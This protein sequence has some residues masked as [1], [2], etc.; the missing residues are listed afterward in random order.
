MNMHAN[1]RPPLASRRIVG[2]VC[3]IAIA[4]FSCAPEIPAPEGEPGECVAQC[5]G[6]VCGSDGCGG[7]C[8][9]CGGQQVCNTFGI[10]VEC[11]D[12]SQ[13]DYANPCTPG[14]CMDG[15]CQ[16]EVL[17]D[18]EVCA[19]GMECKQGL[20]TSVTPP[21]QPD[22]AGKQCG[23]DGCG[24]ECAS[25]PEGLFCSNFV[26]SMECE[27]EC[28][29]GQKQC[30]GAGFQT[31][32]PHDEHTC[33]VWGPVTPCGIGEKCLEGKCQCDPDCTGKQCGPDGCGGI[34]G[35]CGPEQ[36]CGQDFHCADV[37]CNECDF[38]QQMQCEDSLE[39][40]LCEYNEEGCLLWSEDT[41]G[42]AEGKVCQN[43]ECKCDDQCQGKECGPDGCGGECGS[44]PDGQEC[45]AGGSCIPTCTETCVSS[46]C[47]CGVVCG[48]SCGSC[49]LGWTCK[50][51]CHCECQ[52]SCEGKQCGDDGCGESCGDCQP[53]EVCSV[54]DQCHCEDECADAGAKQCAWSGY[55]VC[56]FFGSDDCLTW[57]DEIPCPLG[58]ECVQGSCFEP[59]GCTVE[60]CG[61]SQV[62]P[63]GEECYC[64]QACFDFGDCC[65]DVCSDCWQLQGCGWQQFGSHYYL[66]VADDMTWD[67]AR[68]YC[69]YVGGDLVSILGDAENSFVFDLLEDDF[70]SDDSW[71]GFHQSPSTEIWD[72]N[73]VW[74]DGAVA[75]G[76]SKWNDGEPNDWGG[77]PPADGGGDEGCAAMYKGHTVNISQKDYHWND[78]PCGDQLPFVCK[79]PAQ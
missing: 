34:C 73:W 36:S 66:Y 40:K 43:N 45:N 7:S 38:D 15:V 1:E 35:E 58:K 50:D 37:A 4:A 68:N 70:G 69:L 59:G 75:T 71:I 72:A 78:V 18:G 57:G 31:C 11:V 12:D 20:C 32:G 33:L 63:P 10:C 5:D 3:A 52:G 79:K 62:T 8:G 28:L 76:Y 24:N 26:C 67:T 9:D 54:D 30:Y 64:D 21:C 17:A 56:S 39:Y 41:Y 27:T 61:V 74:S 53:N 55:Q 60:T 23:D 49:E 16:K 47:D 48:T 51:N 77:F 25:C 46:D 6:K 29:A 14:V 65:N 2:A 42:C 19:P 22:C 13:C 44:C